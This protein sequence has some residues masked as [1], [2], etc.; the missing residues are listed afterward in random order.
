MWIAKDWNDYEL[1]GCGNGLGLERWGNRR[2][3]RPATQ[4]SLHGMV[5]T[6]C[7]MTDAIHPARAADIGNVTVYPSDGRFNIENCCLR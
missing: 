3:L 6:A 7:Y 4:S 1:L 5:L 2:I